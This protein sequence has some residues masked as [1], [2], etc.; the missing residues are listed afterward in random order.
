[1]DVHCS[2]DSMHGQS[3]S[4]SSEQVR[5]RM[6]W[7]GPRRGLQQP[8]TSCWNSHMQGLRP[9]MSQPQAGSLSCFSRNAWP[10]ASVPVKLVDKIP[11]G[12]IDQW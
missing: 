6:S 11:L 3:R 7:R 4:P 10:F 1:M 12:L 9:R 5:Q 8:T 2:A